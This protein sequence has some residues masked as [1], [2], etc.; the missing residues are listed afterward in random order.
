M[1][2]R[3]LSEF[4]R[5]LLTPYDVQAALEELTARIAVVLGLTGSGVSLCRGDRLEFD[6]GLGGAAAELEKVQ[7]RTQDGPC[8]TAFRTGVPVTVSDLVTHGR[9]PAY[10]QAAAEVGIHAVA[11]IPLKI[12]DRSVGALN[13]YAAE[14]REWHPD[15]VAAAAVMGDMATGYLLHASAHKQQV[16][17][18]DQLQH[19]L[20]HRLVI[21]QAKGMLAARHETSPD[22]AFERL[23]R[24][25]RSKGVSVHAV[26][27]AVVS[28]GM[29]LD[30]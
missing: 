7:Q 27:D 12:G 9:W 30:S 11:S 5:A 14:P 28:L 21:E 1:Y 3:T 25:A 20:D 10:E 24:H 6:T 22:E 8:V 4:A 29:D 13:L 18:A 16:E 19:A 26:A 2:L 15:D 17:L 23:R